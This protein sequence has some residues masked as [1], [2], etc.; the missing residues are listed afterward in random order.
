MEQVNGTLE[1]AK[2]SIGV[3]KVNSVVSTVIRR[4][5]DFKMLARQLGSSGTK[6]GGKQPLDKE[7]LKKIAPLPWFFRPS[8]VFSR[9]LTESAKENRRKEFE[10]YLRSIVTEKAHLT[11]ENYYLAFVFL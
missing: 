11:R 8:A 9:E 7:E 5:S 2:N 6:G 4:K 10:T 1:K 3:K